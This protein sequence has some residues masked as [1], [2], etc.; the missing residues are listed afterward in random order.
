MSEMLINFYHAFSIPILDKKDDE[1]SN[2]DIETEDSG[3]G[4]GENNVLYFVN[5]LLKYCLKSNIFFLYYLF[6][7]LIYIIRIFKL[8]KFIHY[9]FIAKQS[10]ISKKFEMEILRFYLK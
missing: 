8:T 10:I 9:I 1:G 7:L 5:T 6:Y 4:F 2:N 3:Y